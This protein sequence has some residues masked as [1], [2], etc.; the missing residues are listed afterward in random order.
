MSETNRIPSAMGFRNLIPITFTIT[1]ILTTI[2]ALKF[3]RVIRGTILRTMPNI[4]TGTTNRVSLLAIGFSMAKRPTIGTLFDTKI[5]P[6]TK[7]LP[8]KTPCFGLK[9]NFGQKEVLFNKSSL[10]LD[11]DLTLK[12]NSS[13]DISTGILEIKILGF[14]FLGRLTSN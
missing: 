3:R 7:T 12:N 10:S 6:K 9:R 14:L 2:N 13:P 5:I 1:I 4:A 8:L 11:W